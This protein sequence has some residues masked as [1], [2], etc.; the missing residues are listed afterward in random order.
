M[1]EDYTIK[2]QLKP[3]I[4]SMRIKMIKREKMMRRSV[5][6]IVRAL[7]IVLNNTMRQLQTAKIISENNNRAAKMS[8]HAIGDNM[9]R[10]LQ[11]TEGVKPIGTKDLRMLKH[12]IVQAERRITHEL[13]KA[14][15][16]EMSILRKARGFLKTLRIKTRRSIIELKRTT[17][18]EYRR[19][20]RKHSRRIMAVLLKQDNNLQNYE[21]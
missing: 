10:G 4:R 1:A 8:L 14:N 2:S 18:R 17:R 3:I 19:I 9:A 20:Y 12:K 7:M 15:R 13:H 21:Y 5:D 11:Q 6:K 16:R